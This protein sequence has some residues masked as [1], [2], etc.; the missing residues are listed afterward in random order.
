MHSLLAFGLVFVVMMTDVAV[1]RPEP[2]PMFL[3]NRAIKS[4]GFEVKKA[5]Q[6]VSRTSVAIGDSADIPAPAVQISDGIS[7]TNKDEV[8]PV[9]TSKIPYA[10]DYIA[11]V[12][13]TSDLVSS[14]PVASKSDVT[15]ASQTI[16]DPTE[17]N[18]P[19]DLPVASKSDVTAESQSIVDPTELNN[20]VDLPVASKLDDTVGSPEAIDQTEVNSPIDNSANIGDADLANNS[21]PASVLDGSNPSDD[22]TDQTAFT[23]KKLLKKKAA[24]AKKSKKINKVPSLNRVRLLDSLID[25]LLDS[26]IPTNDDIRRS[27]R[28]RSF[29]EFFDYA[30][31]SSPY[32]FNYF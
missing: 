1:A 18:N 2:L 31:P 16:V 19:V 21:E 6:N 25:L 3:A 12:P 17:L 24:K 9:A 11:D 22:N 20:P 10:K 4:T 14:L 5:D 15:A 29:D 23:E 8:S 26:L 13:A 28:S 30:F 27:R 7:E 32:V